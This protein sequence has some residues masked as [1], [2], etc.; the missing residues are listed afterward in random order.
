[1]AYGFGRLVST[2]RR[3]KSQIST[4]CAL[5]VLSG[6]LRG[7]VR[8]DLPVQQHSGAFRGSIPQDTKKSTMNIHELSV[9]F[10]YVRGF[11]EEGL[12]GIL[13]QF[14]NRP[15]LEAEYSEMTKSCLVLGNHH[16]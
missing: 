10:P 5:S 3:A 12:V 16:N 14:L 15:G 8:R 13:K 1:M 7:P 6:V 4:T 2:P 9:Y 11:S